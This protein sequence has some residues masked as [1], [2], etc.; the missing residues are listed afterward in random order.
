MLTHIH[1]SCVR[2]TCRTS[3]H[4]K[5]T[6]KFQHSVWASPRNRQVPRAPLPAPGVTR[7]LRARRAPRRKALPSFV[8]HTSS[9]A[10]PKPSPPPL[11]CASY[12]AGLCRLLPAPAGRWSF[13]TLSLRIFPQDAWTPTHGGSEWCPFARFLPHGTSAF[14]CVMTNGSATR[15]RSRFKQLRCRIPIS[16]A[17]S[18]SIIVQAL[19]VCS[20]PRLHPTVAD[21]TRTH[22]GQ[23]RSTF[24]ASRD[25][26][27]PRAS[28]YASHLNRAN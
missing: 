17:V 2:F 3:S 16:R 26:L 1:P 10:R 12:P 23:W 21:L 27:P 9:C 4:I 6:A 14:P 11:V 13:P 20:P 18:H 25:S 22:G 7:G 28:E 24:R 15:Q 19:Q 8:A 5:G